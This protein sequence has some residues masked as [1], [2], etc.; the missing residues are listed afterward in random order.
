M[1]VQAFSAPPATVASAATPAVDE[2]RATVHLAPTEPVELMR[3]FSGIT[4]YATALASGAIQ[5]PGP[6][7]LVRALPH[8]LAWS[9]F[10]PAVRTLLA[11]PGPVPG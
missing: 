10:A 6:P 4:P 2:E 11:T 9:P 1:L 7:R 3:I 8:W 5:V